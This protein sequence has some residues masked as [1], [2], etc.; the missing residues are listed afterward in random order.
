MGWTLSRVQRKRPAE[1]R[2]DFERDVGWTTQPGR[3]VPLPAVAHSTYRA[4]SFPAIGDE[5]RSRRTVAARAGPDLWPGATAANT[6][7]AMTSIAIGCWNT[8]V[9]P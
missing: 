4:L 1:A 7:Y 3:G 8:S 5:Q 9:E 2:A 6:S